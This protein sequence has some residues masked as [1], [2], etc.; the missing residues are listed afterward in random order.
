MAG[1]FG[2][3]RRWQ[4]LC[5]GVAALPFLASGQCQSWASSPASSEYTGECLNWKDLG[6][7]TYIHPSSGQCDNWATAGLPCPASFQTP[8]TRHFDCS[9]PVAC[10]VL[11]L[12]QQG[13]S[14]EQTSWP[15]LRAAG[16]L[17]KV[18]CGA[19]VGCASHSR[20][21]LSTSCI[22][23]ESG[24]HTAVVGQSTNSASF[25]TVASNQFDLTLDTSGLLTGDHRLCIDLDGTGTAEQFKDMGFVVALA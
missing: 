8:N 1:A 20:A 14:V 21:Y 15:V 2:L 6:Q 25:T 13:L 23:A 3:I 4:L 5:I 11:T 22:S 9:D 19:A 10:P 17:L 24:V 18:T 12:V 7:A 16:Q